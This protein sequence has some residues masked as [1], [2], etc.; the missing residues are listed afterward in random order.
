MMDKEQRNSTIRY[1]CATTPACILKSRIVTKN[2][3][4]EIYQEISRILVY[5]LAFSLFTEH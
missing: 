2:M 3:E 4:R 5:I 1:S